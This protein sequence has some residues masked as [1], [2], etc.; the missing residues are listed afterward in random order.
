[1]RG[2]IEGD[3]QCDVQLVPRRRAKYSPADCDRR[4]GV[5]AEVAY[6]WVRIFQRS[7][8][9]RHLGRLVQLYN[10]KCTMPRENIRIVGNKLSTIKVNSVKIIYKNFLLNAG[11]TQSSVA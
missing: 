10:V 5:D 7:Q 1:M 8:T 6:T 4:I 11:I 2:Q 9:C 3:A